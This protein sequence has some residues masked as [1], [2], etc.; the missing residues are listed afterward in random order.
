M[1]F[2]RWEFIRKHP[3]SVQLWGNKESGIGKRGRLGCNT[4]ATKVLATHS[5]YGPLELAHLNA[6]FYAPTIDQLLDTDNLLEGCSLQ[7]R[8]VSRE[9]P[10]WQ[11]GEWTPQTQEGDWKHKQ[12]PL[13]YSTKLGSLI[14]L[15]CSFEERRRLQQEEK[16]E[17][18][19][20]SYPQNIFF[21]YFFKEIKSWA[22][23]QEMARVQN[24]SFWL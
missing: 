6:S 5:W 12:H 21:R 20:W 14:L 13:H 3:Q 4:V 23:N 2:S 19:K 11:L 7:L 24:F 17:M 16:S 22:D 8:A 10:T 18:I 1:V 15:A 9:A